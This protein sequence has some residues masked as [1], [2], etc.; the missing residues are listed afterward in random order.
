[1]KIIQR[2]YY[3]RGLKEEFA[4]R[5]N[6]LHCSIVRTIARLSQLNHAKNF[7]HKVA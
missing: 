1:M 2:T 7:F 3:G 4:D 6:K 5:I